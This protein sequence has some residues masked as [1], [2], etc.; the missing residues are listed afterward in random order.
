LKLPST[1]ERDTLWCETNCPLGASGSVGF[2][3]DAVHSRTDGPGLVL[4]FSHV[5]QAELTGS[6]WWSSLVP[7]GLRVHAVVH[8]IRCYSSK[9]RENFEK[10][11]RA[12]SSKYRDERVPRPDYVY[13]T[14]DIKK[15]M[16]SDVFRDLIREDISRAYRIAVKYNKNVYVLFGTELI[17]FFVPWS[18]EYNEKYLRGSWWKADIF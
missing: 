4:V 18:S 3:P 7:S 17:R 10:A 15:V 5:S 16:T 1:I 8:A 9:W 13:C 11:G 12:C 14:L 6:R 2:V